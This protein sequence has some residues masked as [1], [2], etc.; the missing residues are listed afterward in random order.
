MSKPLVSVVVASVNGLP[1]LAECLD[2][3]LDEEEDGA[4]EV[5][6]ADRVGGA[7]RE[8]VRR[9]DPARVQLVEAGS[10]TSIPRLRALAMAHARGRLIVILEDHCNVAPGWL[11]ALIQAHEDGWR[12]I[13]GAVANA[14]TDRVVDRAVFFCEY[15]RFMPPLDRGPVVEITG[16]NSAYDRELL[17]SLGP[18]LDDEVWESFLHQRMSESGE[19]FFCE[20]SMLVFHKKHFEF[21]YFVSQR[22]HYSRSFAGMRLA[23]APLWR[24]LAYALATPLLPPLLFLRILRTVWAKGQTRSFLGA[25]PALVAF[26]I[27]WAWGET[28]GALFGPGRSLERVE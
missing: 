20:P 24:R 16:N 1:A 23:G 14:C 10:E 18:E 21:L 22:Y 28:I 15:A 19:R 6:V 5:V 3:L 7:T 9:R 13:G 8:S 2:A 25:A 17:A 4:L 26:L 27:P 11:R 12:A